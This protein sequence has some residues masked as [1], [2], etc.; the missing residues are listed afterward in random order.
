[1]NTPILCATVTASTMAGLRA[2]R[3]EAAGVADVVE[4]RLDG[5]EDLDVE[6]AL[7]G[8]RGPVIVTCRP[9]REGGRFDGAED[10]RLGVLDQASTL[11]AEY[12]DVEWDARHAPLI[13]RRGGRGVIVSSHDFRG[14]P[15]DLRD[16]FLA[17]R[18]TGA[19][20]VKIA[21]TAHRLVD[22]LPLLALGR[23][24]AGRGRVALVAMGESGLPSR[25]LAA[26]FGSCWTYSGDG[27]APGQM[28]PAR[29][30][31]EF[32][33]RA[34]TASSR[35][36]GLVGRPVGHSVS[37]AMHNA[38]FGATGV[39]AV[40]LPFAARDVADFRTFAE[41]LGVAGASITVPFKP[42]V[43]RAA[44]EADEPA[45]RCG[46][47]NTLLMGDGRWVAR[48]ADV[49][50][51]L[52]PLDAR[53]IELRGARCAVLG[54]GG[55]A[56]AVVVALAGRGAGVT[57]YGRREDAAREVAGLV[58]GS[59]AQAGL[60]RAG[61]FDILVN[62]TPVG[63][64]PD[65]DAS[66]VES[67][68][69]SEGGLVYDLVY[70]PEKTVLLRQAEA[71]GCA[72]VSGLEML[73]AQAGRQFEWWTGIPAPREVMLAAAVERLKEMAGRE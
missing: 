25:I 7:S 51:F 54:T 71:A 18:A 48:N 33:F 63:M 42:D 20:V 39:D 2:A 29:M 35:V 46:A 61:T 16:R 68:V 5:V 41:A 14:A 27:V 58:R 37:P 57:V 19:E 21:V 40:Y 15:T 59:A 34:V 69:L 43:L 11:G 4:L 52:V 13:G 23:E 10:E 60:P 9:T 62:A 30:V 45:R 70:N 3:D 32:R 8:R 66:P 44:D 50:G 22:N 64:W 49:D 73:I 26:R 56:R 12:V 17:M 72:V 24:A 28:T 6:G 47:A 53:G 31:S 55:A 1:M 67:A 36:F 65:V 38:A